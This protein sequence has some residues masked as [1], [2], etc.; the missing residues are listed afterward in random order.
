MVGKLRCFKANEVTVKFSIEA[1]LTAALQI[2]DNGDVYP[3]ICLLEA[4]A[5]LA[6]DCS[7]L[8]VFQKTI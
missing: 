5:G 2:Q 4:G 1:A 8:Q 3:S 6:S 7:V